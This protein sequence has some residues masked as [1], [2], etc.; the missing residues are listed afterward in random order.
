MADKTKV[1]RPFI[2][3]KDPMI[4]K[5]LKNFLNGLMKVYLITK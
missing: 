1:I 4:Q 3:T 2:M 5:L